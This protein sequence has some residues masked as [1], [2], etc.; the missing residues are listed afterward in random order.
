MK[1]KLAWGW[2]LGLAVV[3]SALTA[4]AEE[5]LEARQTTVREVHGEV[6]TRSPGGEWQPAEKGMI[7]NE[8]DEIRTGEG[9]TAQVALDDG[10]V[11]QV[12]IREKS[13]FRIHT[14]KQSRE[15]G[16][17]TTLLDLA[18]GKV[19]VHAKKLKG[20]SKFEVR[21]PTATTGVRGTVF[22]V[23]VEPK[24]QSKGV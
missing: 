16:D 24:D 9:A 4:H 14:L 15:S 11:G 12:D 8:K 7:L 13:Y 5:P 10:K 19:L 6:L 22:E 23:A 20:N 21:T 2:M 18:I 1:N 17:R 3:F